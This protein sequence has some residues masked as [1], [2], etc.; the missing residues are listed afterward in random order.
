M[1]ILIIDD[2]EYK[3]KQIKGS[4]DRVCGPWI[5]WEKSRN[6]GLASIM[7]HNIN[8]DFKPYDMVI[9][10]NIMPLFDNESELE[11]FASDIVNEIRRLG[12]ED[13]IVVVC[14]ADEIEECDYNYKIKY[15]SSVS[16]DENF[17]IIFSDIAAYN[18]IQE[19]P[20]KKSIDVSRKKNIEIIYPTKSEIDYTGVVGKARL[21][22]RT[23]I[24]D[25]CASY[26]PL[27]LCN[28]LECLYC[29]NCAYSIELESGNGIIK[30]D[31]KIEEYSKEHP[32]GMTDEEHEILFYDK[33]PSEEE[34]FQY[35]FEEESKYKI[36]R[37]NDNVI[38]VDTTKQIEEKGPVKKLVPNNKI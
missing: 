31:K 25:S 33:V 15:D 28:I 4:L 36:I 23:E 35:L 8:K 3:Y 22:H 16:L 34:L 5:S 29:E 10:D 12:L 27:G 26:D 9:V 37:K 18:M 30:S 19:E 14:S 6:S 13:L 32:S 20:T 21:I 38:M 1:R 11:P 17:K 2:S 24:V 7:K